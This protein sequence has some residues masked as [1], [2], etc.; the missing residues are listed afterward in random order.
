MF[1]LFIDFVGHCEFYF[2][3]SF[4]FADICLLILFHQTNPSHFHV[5]QMSVRHVD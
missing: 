2:S 3:V 4:Y 5:V 1:N